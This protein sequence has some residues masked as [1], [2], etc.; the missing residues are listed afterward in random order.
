M[1]NYVYFRVAGRYAGMEQYREIY[2]TSRHRTYKPYG[3]TVFH[4]NKYTTLIRIPPTVFKL[5]FKYDRQSGVYKTSQTWG[6]LHRLG[7]LEVWDHG[8]A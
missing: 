2:L 5:F 3:E 8:E 6:F 4:N 7:A 1:A